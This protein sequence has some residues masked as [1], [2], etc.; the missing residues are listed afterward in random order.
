MKI[1][2]CIICG[3]HARYVSRNSLLAFCED[4]YAEAE[5]SYEDVKDAD[6]NMDF[7]EYYDFELAEDNSENVRLA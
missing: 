2:K 1:R 6:N 4:C 3:C 7:S 5:D